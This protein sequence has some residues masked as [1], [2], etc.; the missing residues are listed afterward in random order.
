[1]ISKTPSLTTIPSKL[2]PCST[3]GSFFGGRFS[4]FFGVF[5][6]FLPFLS[7]GLETGLGRVGSSLLLMDSLI[8]TTS[9]SSF[10]D[11]SFSF[12][13]LVFSSDLEESPLF[14]EALLAGFLLAGFLCAG[15]FSALTVSLFSSFGGLIACSS[16]IL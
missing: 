3:A 10:E 5:C 2:Y 13:S 7:P 4:F 15:F 14:S 16:K 6:L 9:S 1:M 8:S 11:E 12:V